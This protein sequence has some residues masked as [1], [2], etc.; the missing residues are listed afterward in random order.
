M[1]IDYE[2]IFVNDG[3]PDNSAEIIKDITK[4][5]RR[6]IG[7]THSR[8]FGSQMAFRSG[9]ELASKQAVVLLDG[10]LQDPPELINDFAK[11]WD[12]GND[13]VY[14]VRVKREM[15]FYWEFMYKAF[16]RIL[17]A[18]SFIK[19]PHDAGDFSLLDKRVVSWVLKCPE[20]DLFMR[21]IRAFV[22]FKQTGV[23]YTRPERMFGTSTNNLMKNIG[24]AKMGILSFTNAPLNLMSF[25]GVIT[26]LISFVLGLTFILLKIFF[27]EIAPKG[28]TTIMLLILIFGSINIFAIALV[29]EY[30]GKI[31]SEVK[32]RPRLIRA[33]IIRDGKIKKI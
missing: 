2:I 9:M 29:G 7:I 16:Y 18:I 19:I 12:D 17:S 31:M 30:V 13:V 20:R 8:N 32:Q 15:P 3:S 5:D 1:R 22:G 24:W 11:K 6:V 25:V 4:N 10:D 26:L 23:N 21:G 33:E 14:G 27:P 28:L